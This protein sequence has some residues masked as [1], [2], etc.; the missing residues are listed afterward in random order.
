MCDFTYVYV[1]SQRERKRRQRF[2]PQ[3]VVKKMGAHRWNVAQSSRFG[4]ALATRVWLRRRTRAAWGRSGRRFC[5]WRPRRDELRSLGASWNAE[6]FR[7][8]HSPSMGR[9]P[10]SSPF[11]TWKWF[12]SL[13]RTAPACTRSIHMD[14]RC[15]TAPPRTAPNK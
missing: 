12:A 11:K 9:R 15:C 13:C 8:T 3:C 10:C 5:T 4:C 2:F 7:S 1:R 14:A 6:W